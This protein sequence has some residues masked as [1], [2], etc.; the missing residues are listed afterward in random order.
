MDGN[1]ETA[2][3]RAQCSQ[4]SVE[5]GGGGHEKLA[6]TFLTANAKLPH[7]SVCADVG[8]AVMLAPEGLACPAGDSRRTRRAPHRYKSLWLWLPAIG[9]PCGGG[10]RFGVRCF[11]DLPL[12]AG[13]W[14]MSRP[15][16]PTTP[17]NELS[18]RSLTNPQVLRDTH[19]FS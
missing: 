15:A 14:S 8:E 1:S 10:Q 6:A 16:V 4:R 9:F 2:G 13:G 11:P 3:P 12:S 19:Q 17:W 7:H 5:C 18:P